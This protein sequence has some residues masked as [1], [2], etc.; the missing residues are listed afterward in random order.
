MSIFTRLD[1]GSHLYF[2]THF[3]TCKL[4]FD[5][6]FLGMELSS[7]WKTKMLALM[8]NCRYAIIFP[9]AAIA[10]CRNQFVLGTSMMIKSH[11]AKI[12]RVHLFVAHDLIARIKVLMQWVSLG[13]DTLDSTYTQPL[14]C[15]RGSPL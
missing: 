10:I 14:I 6:P 1:V 13:D 5:H 9:M 11:I 2:D 15:H 7:V 12:L 4:E 3:N 8:G